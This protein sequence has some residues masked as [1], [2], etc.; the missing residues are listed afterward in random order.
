MIKNYIGDKTYTTYKIQRAPV[1]PWFSLAFL[2]FL[3]VFLIIILFD[4]VLHVN[5][6]EVSK[7]VIVFVFTLLGIPLMSRWIYVAFRDAEYVFDNGDSLVGFNR[8]KRFVGKVHYDEVVSIRTGFD[9]CFKLYDSSG[10]FLLGI[11][12]AIEN[13]HEF[14]NRIIEKSTSLRIVEL[15]RIREVQ[16]NLILYKMNK[17]GANNG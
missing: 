5:R 8:Y 1:M 2:V 3:I 17:N 16:P 6:I 12:G 7:I 13:S 11:N 4:V 9:V 15:E 14:I 10:K